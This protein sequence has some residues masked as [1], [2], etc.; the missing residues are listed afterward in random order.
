MD[1]IVGQIKGEIIPLNESYFDSARQVVTYWHKCRQHRSMPSWPD[2]ELMKLPLELV[3][4][5][6]V[7][8]RMDDPRN[9]I[10]RFFG[11]AQVTAHGRDLTGQSLRGNYTTE[12]VDFIF[13]QYQTVI[14]QMVPVM[15]RIQVPLENNVTRCSDILRCPL[16]DDDQYVNVILSVEGTFIDRSTGQ[17]D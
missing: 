12:L 15:F 10:Y 7:V 11:T 17:V 8:D 3:P 5:T 6:L 2:F 9:F 4:R 1:D 14:G 13:D 16:S